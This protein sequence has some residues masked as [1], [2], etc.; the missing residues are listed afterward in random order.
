MKKEEKLTDEQQKIKDDLL[1]EWALE[2]AKLL[3]ETRKLQAQVENLP[4]EG[5]DDWIEVG[6]VGV[7]AGM[8]WIGDPC[9]ILAL[10]HCRQDNIE[11]KKKDPSW[12]H[13][14]DLYENVRKL[15]AT[16]GD[17][18]HAFCD[19]MHSDQDNPIGDRAYKK[20]LE[21]QLEKGIKT[22]QEAV[23][24]NYEA[25]HPGL[26]VCVGSGYGDGSYPVYVKRNREGRIMEAKVVFIDESEEEEEEDN[27]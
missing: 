11:E 2:E 14:K 23:Q 5:E 4:V 26:G 25:G 20:Y 8:V 22:G 15:P 10:P 17:S 18:W 19:K 9:Y 16:L 13:I 12:E 3:E 27:E 21:K 6:Q 1:L 24:F 7:D